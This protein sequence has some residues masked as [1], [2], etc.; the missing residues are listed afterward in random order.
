VN[1]WNA[2]LPDVTYRVQVDGLTPATTYYY[3]VDAAHADG[4]RMGLK[5]TVNQFATRPRP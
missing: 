3:T 4:I 2:N 1:R 5:S